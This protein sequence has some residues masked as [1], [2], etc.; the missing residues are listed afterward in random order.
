M[1]EGLKT[2]MSLQFKIFKSQIEELQELDAAIQSKKKL[3][4][5]N[6]QKSTTR[7]DDTV[8]NL[9]PSVDLDDFELQLVPYIS[10]D[11]SF[12]NID[13]IKNVMAKLVN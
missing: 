2:I 9:L 12:L 5:S 10:E 3:E 4:S 1:A 7:K 11:G 8:R 13:A 6:D